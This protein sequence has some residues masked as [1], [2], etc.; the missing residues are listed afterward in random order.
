M[1]LLCTL[2][3][4]TSTLSKPQPATMHIVLYL[5]STKSISIQMTLVN[6]HNKY[7]I[8]LAI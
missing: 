3:K 2:Y 1:D 5:H 8:F 7:E 4:W 6:A